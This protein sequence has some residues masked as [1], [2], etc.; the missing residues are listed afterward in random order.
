MDNLSLFK[1]LSDALIK[2]QSNSTEQKEQSSPSGMDKI[3]DLFKSFSNKK[4]QE[5]SNNTSATSAKN[6]KPE[7]KKATPL[8]PL[9]SQMLGTMKSHDEFIK[10]VMKKV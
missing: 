4:T 2:T 7:D 9:Q 5:E 10:R 3:L 8:V 1:L 6:S